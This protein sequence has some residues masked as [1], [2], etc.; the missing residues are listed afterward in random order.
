MPTVELSCEFTYESAHRLPEVDPRHKCA[1]THGH[2]YHL[3][4]TVRGPVREDG[5]VVDFADIK[6]C[7]NPLI[8]VLDHHLL[9]EIPG[10]E[11]PTVEN[12]LVWVWDR[13]ELPGLHELTLRETPTN[14][15]TYKGEN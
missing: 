13:L 5:F 12:Q 10:L 4:V 2:S 9:N 14:S 11:N 3:T 6:S 8:T 15:A 7:V 1:R